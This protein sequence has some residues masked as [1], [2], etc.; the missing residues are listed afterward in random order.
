MATWKAQK[1]YSLH[2]K[3]QTEEAKKLYEEAIQAGLD[4]PRFLLSYSV[5]LI[6]SG[7]YEKARELLRKTEKAP[8]ITEE[9]KTQLFTNYAACQYRLGSLDKAVDLLEKRHK[10]FPCG[11]IYQTLGYLYVEKFDP[12]HA[13][14]FDAQDAEMQARY[15]QAVQEA[16]EEAE[17]GEEIELPEKPVPTRQAFA[18]HK[19]R[20]EAF[21]LEA[22]DYDDED[23][24]CLDNLAQW[25]YRVTCDHEK[26]LPYFEKALEN[27]ENQIDTL[28]FLSRYDLERGDTAKAL[29]RL[30][31]ARGG[32][33]SPLNYADKETIE[34]EIQRLKG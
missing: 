17:E 29:E 25:Y 28:Y 26:A 6:R 1:A 30:E 14:D 3:G 8:G 24:I 7:E 19:A 22:V 4:A 20:A 33:F 9:Q 12:A 16:R 13:P 5:L 34:R 18:D 11:M 32:R 10:R 31:T 2:S 21:L 27:K 15:E 23:S